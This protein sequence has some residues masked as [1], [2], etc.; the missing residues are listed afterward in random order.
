MVGSLSSRKHGTFTVVVGS[1]ENRG[2][3]DEEEGMLAGV[4]GR[5]GGIGLFGRTDSSKTTLVDTMIFPI[6]GFH[7]LYAFDAISYPT[8][9]IGL[10]R[11]SHFLAWS[12][13]VHA[14]Q[15]NT[16]RCDTSSSPY[17]FSKTIVENI[18][19]NGEKTQ[20]TRENPF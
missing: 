9:I 17:D 5:A 18:K 12:S 19:E 1:G 8:N 7:S 3:L 4:G 10:D 16:Q 6:S 11:D 20:G 13:K 15:P 14:R 2:I